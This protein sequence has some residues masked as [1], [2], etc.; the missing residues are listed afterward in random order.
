M[1]ILANHE[2]KEDNGLGVFFGWGEKSN[3]YDFDCQPL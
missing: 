2:Y 3:I 1:N